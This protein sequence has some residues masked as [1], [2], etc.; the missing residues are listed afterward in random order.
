MLR[1]SMSPVDIV[2]KEVGS[3]VVRLLCHTE[4]FG[5]FVITFSRDGDDDSGSLAA[6]EIAEA[7]SKASP[8]DNFMTNPV[9]AVQGRR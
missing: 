1:Q 8:L 4:H 6:T 7:K 5:S 2:S 3:S 9:V